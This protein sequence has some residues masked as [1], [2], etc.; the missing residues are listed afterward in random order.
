MIHDS[1]S[2]ISL[3]GVRANAY[4]RVNGHIWSTNY[5]CVSFPA[6]RVLARIFYEYFT[7]K[8]QAVKKIKKKLKSL[9]YQR[10][11]KDASN[12][13]KK[14][15]SNKTRTQGCATEAVQCKH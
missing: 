13:L 12:D 5:K 1:N 2:H 6:I 3:I 10:K 11:V 8:K 9:Q 15:D 7:S 4:I 14:H